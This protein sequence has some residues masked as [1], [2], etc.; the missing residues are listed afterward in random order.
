MANEKRLIDADAL[1]EELSTLTMTITGLRA[2]KGVLREFM[3]EYRKSVLRIIDEQPTVD[4]VPVEPRNDNERC[5]Y[6]RGA[7][8]TD[9]PFKVITQMNREVEV[10]FNYCPNCGAKMD[11]GAENGKAD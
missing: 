8:Y 7:S 11:G 3:M 1:S 4:A 10:Q 2:G 9:K 5:E 6:C